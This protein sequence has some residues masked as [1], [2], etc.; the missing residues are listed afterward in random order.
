MRGADMVKC[1]IKMLKSN[2]QSKENN[3]EYYLKIFLKRL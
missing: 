1:R 2:A 3:K